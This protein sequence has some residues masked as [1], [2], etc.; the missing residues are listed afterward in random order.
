MIWLIGVLAAIGTTASW[1]P[2]AVKT[3]RT[4]SAVD[5]SWAYL[6]LFGSGVT[7]WSI[8]GFL[9]SDPVILGANVITLLFLLPII[10]AKLRWHSSG[11]ADRREQR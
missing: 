8:Y 11:T 7:L 10:F 5:F 2:Q 9:R 3:I 4:R 1:I 6:F